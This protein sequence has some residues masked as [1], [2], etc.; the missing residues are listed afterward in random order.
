MTLATHSLYLFLFLQFSQVLVKDS[1]EYSLISDY[2]KNT[3][4]ETHSQYELDVL[5]V[6]KCFYLLFLFTLDKCLRGTP[7]Y[8]LYR[9]V[10]PQ[11]VWVFSCFC[12]NRVSILASLLL[13]R[14]CYFAV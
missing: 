9:C 13:N 14:V 3:H 4:A 1:K 5:E 12:Q 2:V 7:L 8:R 6:K 11:R 10:R